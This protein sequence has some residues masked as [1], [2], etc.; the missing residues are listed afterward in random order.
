MNE[1][2]EEYS[3]E[4]DLVPAAYKNDPRYYKNADAF[5]RPPSAYTVLAALCAYPGIDGP[6]FDNAVIT[7][8]PE[9]GEVSVELDDMTHTT[10][11]FGSVQ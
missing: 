5:Y 1:Y 11:I 3:R 10:Y 9:T 6:M 2:F 8:V 4:Q 7:S